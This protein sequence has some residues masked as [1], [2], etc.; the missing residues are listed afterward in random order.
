MQHE[1]ARRDDLYFAGRET[2]RVYHAT[3][4]TKVIA[5]RVREDDR[6]HRQFFDFLVDQFQAGTRR[7]EGRQRIE[8]DPP[9]LAA[10]KGDVGQVQAA[11]LVDAIS[12]L[13]QT[14]LL[15]EL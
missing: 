9:L 3:D 12:H 14:G 7:L 1:F 11:D 4:T 8:N 6:R 5:V 10:H 2:L 13:E 15:V